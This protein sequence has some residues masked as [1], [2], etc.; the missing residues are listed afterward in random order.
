MG[1]DPKHYQDVRTDGA[2]LV[3]GISRLLLDD[4]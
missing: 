1:T 2:M 3:L 4:L